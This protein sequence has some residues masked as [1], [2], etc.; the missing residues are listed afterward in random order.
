MNFKKLYSIINKDSTELMDLIEGIN[1]EGGGSPVYLNLVISKCEGL[2]HGLNLLRETAVGEEELSASEDIFD[3]NIRVEKNSK[4]YAENCCEDNLAE[5]QGDMAKKS[6]SSLE[7]IKIPFVEVEESIFEAKKEEI[8]V[9][10]TVFKD[11]KTDSNKSG[12]NYLINVPIKSLK[13][14]VPLNDKFMFVRELF[15]NNIDKY[16]ECI[17]A[18]DA[19]CGFH[20][21]LAFLQERY[22]WDDDTPALV[23]FQ[24]IVKRR[25]L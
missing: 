23:D 14:E 16:S 2:L 18:L 8:K 24:Q 13:K 6:E 22:T 11:T 19:Q 12:D 21:A 25:F 10:D 4:A 7:P 17:E 5:T 20:E 15:D 9:L 3:R 1:I